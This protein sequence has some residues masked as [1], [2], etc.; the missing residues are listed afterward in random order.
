MTSEYIIEVSESEFHQEVL[1]Y[2]SQLPVIVD[3][4]A[5]WCIPCRTLD[6]ILEKLA[7]EAQGAFR[8][9]KVNVDENPQLAQK[10][11]ISSIPAVKAFHGGQVVDEFTGIRP[12][13]EVREFLRSLAPSARDLI[14]EKGHSL[15]L[16]NQWESAAEAFRQALQSNPD[17]GEALL[18]LAKSELA[19][20]NAASALV[21][22]REFPSN[23]QYT[24]AQ[25][26]LPLAESMANLALGEM[27]V[28]GDGLLESAFVNSLELIGNG[29][30]HSAIDGLLEILGDDKKFRADEMQNV[31]LG[32]LEMLDQENTQVR[33]YRGELSSLLF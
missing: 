17:H 26:L 33:E 20:G 21:V 16:G 19:Q 14:I 29:N 10:Y 9:A 18:G 13:P 3:F 5:E 15:Y 12:E 22:L 4:W 24:V 30:L 11:Q 27:E 1:A 32:A 6:P 28:S 8:L 7:E 31:I 23:K 25:R 2:S